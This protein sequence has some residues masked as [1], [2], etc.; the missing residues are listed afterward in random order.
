MCKSYLLNVL[1]MRNRTVARAIA[2]VVFITPVMAQRA[3]SDYTSRA[4]AAYN[5]G[6]FDQAIA[7]ARE[8]M[9][10]PATANTGAL[11]LSRSLLGRFR[12]LRAPEDL[13]QARAAL[14]KIAA[15]RLS[16]ADYGEYLVA[17]GLSLYL[18]GCADGCYGGAA[19]MFAMALPR[20]ADPAERERVFEW[21]AASLDRQALYGTPET[22]RTAIY[23]RL[24]DGA[25]AELVKQDA[26]LSASYWL[27]AAARGTGDLE[28]AWGAAVAG[29]TRAGGFGDKGQALR[30]DLDRFVRDVLL[31][32]RARLEADP[33]SAYTRLL[34]QWDEIK[35][36]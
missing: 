8:A 28:R 22:D 1:R 2:I 26:S 19:E 3:K 30:T 5:V 13:D 36:K 6:Q 15:D 14:K 9:S 10:V 33:P 25:T 23:R 17:Q 16:P 29:W 24:L 20:A 4:R 34:G 18:D 27:C 7:A 12:V 31:P 21:W 35:K 32:E 11:V